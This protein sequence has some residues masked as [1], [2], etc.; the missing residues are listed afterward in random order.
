ML[1]RRSTLIAAFAAV[2][3]AG[4]ATPYQPIPEGYSGPR[5][6]IADTV[7]IRSSSVANVFAIVQVD[8]NDIANAFRASEGASRGRGFALTALIAKRDLPAK[9]MRLTLLGH[10]ITGA[11]IQAMA[12]QL[13]G[14][15]YEVGGTIDFTP[16]SGVFYIVRGELKKEGSSIWIEDTATGQPVTEKI[17]TKP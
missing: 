5:A 4:C 12:M 8:G 9:P 14:T 16:Q 2:S 1:T 7:M 10:P 11:P 3:L 17:L 13:G 15:Y 6:N